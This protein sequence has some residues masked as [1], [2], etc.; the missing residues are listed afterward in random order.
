MTAASPNTVQPNPDAESLSDF[1]SDYSS[2]DSISF[3]DPDASHVE[4]FSWFP[5]PAGKSPAQPEVDDV[6]HA[7]SHITVASV[8]GEKLTHIERLKA[9]LSEARK[10]IK[11]ERHKNT[12]MSTML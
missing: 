8:F 7:H 1:H 2:E 3:I 10:T 6:Q 11:Y 4:T 12:Y 5:A 9:E